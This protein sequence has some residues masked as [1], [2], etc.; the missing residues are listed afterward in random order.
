MVKYHGVICIYLHWQT[1]EDPEA[2]IL[3][4]CEYYDTACHPAKN[5]GLIATAGCDKDFTKNGGKK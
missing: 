1:T 2:T 5:G 3:A 4:D